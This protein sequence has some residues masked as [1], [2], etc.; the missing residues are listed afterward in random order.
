[1]S[2]EQEALVPPDCELV[3]SEE[4]VSRAIDDLAATINR[5]YQGQRVTVM[6]VL[7]GGLIFC[8]HL[9][10][11]LS[12][13]CLIDYCHATRYRNSTR[14]HELNWLAEPTSDL[15]AAN[16]LIVDDILDEGNTL[17]AIVEYCLE[18]GAASVRTAVLLDKQHDRRI[19]GIE[20]DHA[21]LTV[22]D[23]YVFGFGMD[24]AG[25]YRHL[26]AIYALPNT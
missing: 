7:N 21:A 16:V 4:R 24:H 12:C 2:S 26:G 23:R 1:M 6:C 10:T 9:L 17:K 14:G 5:V 20:A 18:K 11:R 13:D 19:D 8:G 15:A 25:R 3:F 22:D